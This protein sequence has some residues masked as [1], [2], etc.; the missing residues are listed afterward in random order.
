MPVTIRSTEEDATPETRFIKHVP[1]GSVELPNH[2][3]VRLLNLWP[4]DYSVCLDPESKDVGW[5][6]L[7]GWDNNWCRVRELSLPDLTRAA[8]DAR[9]NAAHRILLTAHIERAHG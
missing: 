3:W 8:N 7:E 9:T 5:L 2:R 6:M 4:V 1:A